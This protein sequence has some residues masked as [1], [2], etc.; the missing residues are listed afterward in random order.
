MA[1]AS[2]RVGTW[3]KIGHAAHCQNLFVWVSALEAHGKYVSKHLRP[4][5]DVKRRN[6]ANIVYDDSGYIVKTT[7]K[8]SSGQL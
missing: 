7:S 4:V 6:C 8:N 3:N 1:N 2:P 5:K